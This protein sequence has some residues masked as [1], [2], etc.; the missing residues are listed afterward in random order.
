MNDD[1]HKY[2]DRDLLVSL[3][4]KVDLMVKSIEDHETRI[5][6][7]EVKDNQLEGSIRGIKWIGSFVVGAITVVSSYIGWHSKG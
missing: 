5:R 7:G 3:H 6:G 1:L 4:T 2:S